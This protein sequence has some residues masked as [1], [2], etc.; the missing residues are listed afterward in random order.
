M[1]SDTNRVGGRLP[2]PTLHRLIYQQQYTEA[3]KHFR[4]R[5]QDAKYDDGIALGRLCVEESIAPITEDGL[6]LIEEIVRA[7]PFLVGQVDING[8]TPMLRAAGLRNSP[9]EPLSERRLVLLI[10]ACP[11]ATC[12][13]VLRDGDWHMNSFLFACK[14]NASLD[15]LKLILAIDASFATQAA[16]AESSR[17]D[18]ISA[19]RYAMVIL[20]RAIGGAQNPEEWPKMELLLRAATGAPLDEIPDEG[21]DDEYNHKGQHPNHFDVLRAACMV[22]PCPRDY[23]EILL[24]RYPNRLAWADETGLL[25]LHHA[26]LAANKQWPRQTEFLMEEM[27]ARYPDAAS[28]PFGKHAQD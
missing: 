1:M 25:P 12:A 6:R 7:F 19:D 4:Q 13:R 9:F 16:V 27:V 2:G 22:N 11:E 26:I 18:R 15:L 17:Y 10:Q 14:H 24:Q 23:V 21:E 3:L 8:W 20:W 5:P 28:Y